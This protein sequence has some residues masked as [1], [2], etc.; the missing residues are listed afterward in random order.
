MRFKIFYC[1]SAIVFSLAV[2]TVGCSA[3]QTEQQAQQALREMSKG[4]KS[5]TEAYVASVESRFA[6]KRT[7]AL[8]KL[9]LQPLH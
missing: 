9:L 3:Q 8:A 2:F 5:P 4:N 1:L 7:G 6:G